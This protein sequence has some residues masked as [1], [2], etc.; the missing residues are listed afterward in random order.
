MMVERPDERQW[1]DLVRTYGT[2]MF[3]DHVWCTPERIENIDSPTCSGEVIILIFNLAGSC[4]FVRRRG[5]S[6]WFFPK[7][8]IEV[9]EDIIEVARRQAM[10]E[11]GV[12][13]EPIGVPFCQRITLSFSNLTFQRWHIVVV[14]ETA[15]RDLAPQN[16]EEIEEARLFDIPP[17]VRN[18]YGF[19]WM[20]E[21][22]R[23]AMR[24]LRSLDVMDGI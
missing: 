7:G 18:I 19:S 17:P 10:E 4:I 16:R 22:H 11:A 21:L 23:E 13:I 1:Q 9:G 12:K 2:P 24:Y 20:H 3:L 15:S 6:D 14:A 8:R 5:T